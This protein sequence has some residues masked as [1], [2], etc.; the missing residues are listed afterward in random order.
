MARITVAHL[1]AVLHAIE[2]MS[3]A[4]A[5]GAEDPEFIED[6]RLASEAYPWV[7]AE[8][9]RRKQRKLVRKTVAEIRMNS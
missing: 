9:R 5:V 3:D 8:I 2:C 7:L 6:A 1:E 4:V